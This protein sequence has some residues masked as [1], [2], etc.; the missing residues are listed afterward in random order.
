MFRPEAQRS[1]HIII[2]TAVLT[3]IS[4]TGVHV[5]GAQ[6]YWGVGLRQHSEN[7]IVEKYPFVKKDMSF[8][9][10]YQYHDLGGYWLLS[11][12][13]APDVKGTNLIDNVITPG[14]SPILS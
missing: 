12:D 14:V 7:Q 6:T 10:A 2:I 3:A 11:L 13:Y 8:G 5:N 9:I 1:I 4:G